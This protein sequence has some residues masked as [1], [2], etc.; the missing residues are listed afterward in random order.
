M[1]WFS[2]FFQFDFKTLVKMK[3][4]GFCDQVLARDIMHGYRTRD[5]RF[6][7]NICSVAGKV[8]FDMEPLLDECVELQC[9]NASEPNMDMQVYSQMARFEHQSNG[10]MKLLMVG[11]QPD[12]QQ[13]VER[14]CKV[15]NVAISCGHGLICAAMYTWLQHHGFHHQCN[16]LQQ[17]IIDRF[18]DNNNDKQLDWFHFFTALHSNRNY[19]HQFDR[20]FIDFPTLEVDIAWKLK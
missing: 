14:V 4:V 6:I 8:P 9:M 10:Y 12:N 5:P 15:A 18:N 1:F 16:Q 13:H 11:F 17:H 7:Y 3:V 19:S 20:L 2:F